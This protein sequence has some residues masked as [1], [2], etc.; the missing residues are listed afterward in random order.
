[1]IKAMKYIPPFRQHIDLSHSMFCQSNS[2]VLEDFALLILRIKK[3]AHS[4]RI[5]ITLC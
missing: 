1:M 5:I 4:D 2:L 3:T